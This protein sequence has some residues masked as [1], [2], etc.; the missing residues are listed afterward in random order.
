MIIGDINHVN[1]QNQN[2]LCNI[3]DVLGLYNLVKS[4]TCLKGTPS[5]IDWFITNKPKRF[6]NSVSVDTRL[7]DFHHMVCIATKFYIPK[8]KS[9]VVTYWKYKN[10]DEERFNKQLS[11]IPYYVSEMFDDI[12]D[13]CWFCNTM[14]MQIVNENAPL[15]YRKLKGHRVPYMNE[16]LRQA[17][18]VKNMLKNRI[19]KI[20]KLNSIKLNQ[21]I[22]GLYI[23]S[24]EIMLHS[25][26][27]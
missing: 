12:D 9:A 19:N 10:F 13:T 11:E 18:H 22:I 7:S 3:M 25:Y 15:K 17:I 2:D 4:P 8:L 20:I 26:V 23:N 6:L 24:N 21:Q 5:L 14:I 27:K 1:M 16:Q